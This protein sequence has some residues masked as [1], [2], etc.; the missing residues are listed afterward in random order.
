MICKVSD[1]HLIVFSSTIPMNDFIFG[2]FLDVYNMLLP[3]CKLLSYVPI[4]IIVLG[5]NIVML[6][7][8][9]NSHTLSRTFIRSLTAQLLY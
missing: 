3:L 8:L 1:V 5:V 4:I 2:C 7:S 9:I 6:S